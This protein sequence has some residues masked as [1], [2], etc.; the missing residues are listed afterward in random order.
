MIRGK[1]RTYKRAGWRIGCA[2]SGRLSR[3]LGRTR[4]WTGTRKEWKGERPAKRTWIGMHMV[5]L[6]NRISWHNWI[7]ICLANLGQR[8]HYLEREK[9]KQVNDD[10]DKARVVSKLHLIRRP[11]CFQT[12]TSFRLERVS[13][14]LFLDWK[15]RTVSRSLLFG[16]IPFLA[17]SCERAGIPD[18]VV[19]PWY[20]YVERSWMSLRYGESTR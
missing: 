9:W 19:P 7:N 2:R 20:A 10:L 6:S 3:K 4:N 17:V 1:V 15:T 12:S 18:Q 8:V 16:G 13:G 11:L 14:W 5:L